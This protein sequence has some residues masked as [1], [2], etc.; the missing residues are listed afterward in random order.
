M[1]NDNH[2]GALLHF[3]KDLI[4]YFKSQGIKI[5]LCAPES[6]K[7]NEIPFS[8][9]I[10]CPIKM[11]RTS[12]GIKDNIGYL[13]QLN[14]VINKFHPDL[15]INYT[16]KP[17]IF[18]SLLSF[19]HKYKTISVY[20]GLS[21]ELT[22]LSNKSDKKSRLIFLIIRYILRRNN[23]AFFL[24]KEDL[25][26]MIANNFYDKSNTTLLE[27]GEGVNT[28][29][30]KP[31]NEK[32]DSNRFKIV[33]VGRV[34][35]T[36]GYYEFVDCAQAA[37]SKS[38]PWDFY[39]CGGIDYIHPDKVLKEEIDNS[40]EKGFI[41][42]KGHLNNLKEFISD[43]DC[44]VLPSYYNEGMNRS[45][46]EA[47]S[48]GIP[49]VTTDNRGCRE[50]VIDGKTGYIIP[51]KD[52][53]ALLNSLISIYQLSDNDKRSMRRESREY[54]LSRF[55]VKQIIKIYKSEISRLLPQY[56]LFK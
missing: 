1:L 37:K 22:N 7:E 41:I 11:N 45:L 9:V 25:K 16:L 28:D 51:P 36:K 34:L 44:I 5:I 40:E 23:R 43:A 15:I 46:M 30:Y 29:F 49:I 39:L 35:K 50:L 54:A 38:L 55:D 52:S 6:E 56:N 18:G 47:L 24:N 10:Y 48:M 31:S 4:E 20:A 13:L 14:N 12:K 42:Y 19:L 53:K 3:R 32:K 26:F 21:K 17:I 33:M 8:D 2:L 27:G